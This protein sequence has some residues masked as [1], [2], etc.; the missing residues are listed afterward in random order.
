[1]RWALLFVIDPAL[2]CVSEDGDSQLGDQVGDGG[3]NATPSQLC[4]IAAANDASL[5]SSRPRSSA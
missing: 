1:V 4:D 2:E 3:G 5:I